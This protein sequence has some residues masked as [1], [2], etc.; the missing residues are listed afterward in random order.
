[1]LQPSVLRN[2]GIGA[3]TLAVTLSTLSGCGIASSRSTTATVQE[4]S[5][6]GAFAADEERKPVVLNYGNRDRLT[7]LVNAGFDVW[8]VDEP[9]KRVQGAISSK[10]VQ[11]AQKLGM[12]LG[13]M[14]Q[15]SLRRGF[16]KGYRT[17]E[18]V[19]AT[20]KE[21]AAKNPEIATL[22]DIGDGWEKTQGK[23]N[24]D[25]WALRIRKG[26]GAKPVVVFAGC[27]HAR[28]LVTPEIVLMEAEH[29]VNNYGKD[30]DVTA[31][32]DNRE[33]WIVPMVNP[34]GHAIV[35]TTGVDQRKNA[36]NVT[37]GKRR[38]GTDLNR[39]YDIAWGTVGDSGQPE[40]DTFRGAKPF[41]EPETQAVRDLLLKVKPIIY[42]TF[43]SY[44]NAVMWPWDHKNEAPKDPRLAALGQQL[45]ALS[46]YKAYQGC[47]MYLN[48]GD[49]VDWAFATL[50]TLSYTVEIGGWGD[51]FMPPA[52][53]LPKFWGENAPMMAHALKVAENPGSV[54]GPAT[55]VQPARGA[56]TVAAPG[57]VRAEFFR[58]Q[59]GRP[60]TGT[61]LTVAN[62][63]ATLPTG[64]GR[65][66]LYV[67][68]QGANNVWGPTE[69]VWSN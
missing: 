27:H 58:G 59:V 23:A 62:G 38:V 45:G 56:H 46:G 31:S 17:Y 68:A 26:D 37:G 21:L 20:M 42:M 54:F 3:L 34:D 19:A 8:S 1:M 65:E 18:Q 14:P 61:P 24:R 39:N 32:V 13:K 2:L 63:K 43:H 50:G 52:N 53:R 29:L 49:D 6:L 16:D 5:T 28:E 64:N 25:I 30:A 15:T 22:V 33:I 60:G 47:D 4:W 55:K 57:A 7:Q 48:S 67:R 10:Q 12:T 9:A 41:S 35:E 66:L 44:S 11:L 40:S 36:N 51:G 69:A